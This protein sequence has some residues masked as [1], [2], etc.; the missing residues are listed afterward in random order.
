MKWLQNIIFIVNHYF[1]LAHWLSLDVVAGAIVTHIIACRLPNGHGPV[2][3]ASTLLVGISVFMIYVI[4][5]YLDNRKP[6]HTPTPRHRFQ[7]KY[8]PLLLKILTGLSLAG[9]ILLFWL[10]S[11]VLGF[12]VGL[13]LLVSG[14]LWVVFKL[15]SGHTAQVFKEPLVALI[16]TAGIW[17]PAIL[18]EPVLAW[19]STVLMGLFGLLAFQNL[20]LFSWFESLEIDEGYSLAIAWGPETVA[21]VLNWLMGIIVAGAVCIIIFTDFRYCVR[22]SVVVALMS[23]GMHLLKRYAAGVLKEDRYRRLGDGIFLFTLWLL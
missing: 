17:G 8:E 16:Y 6:D 12:G 13:A 18:T 1:K 22:A 4:D 3:W 7:K 14:Y 2:S 5:R 15:S 19:E 21:A 20:L 10:P 9:L 11:K 23:V